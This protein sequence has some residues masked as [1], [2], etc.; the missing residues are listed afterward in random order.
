MVQMVDGYNVRKRGYQKINS[1]I[2]SI[3]G[4]FVGEKKSSD[5]L[6]EPETNIF[7]PPREAAPLDMGRD[8]FPK[9]DFDFQPSGMEAKNVPSDSQRLVD[10]AETQTTILENRQNAQVAIAGARLFAN[11]MNAQSQYATIA[12]NS[13]TN[14]FLANQSA[15]DAISRGKQQSLAAESQG[16][17]Q[18]D[19]AKLALAAQ[20]QD[21][22]GAGVGKIVAG[23]EAVGIYNGMIAEMNASREALGYEQE[24]IQYMG[25][26]EQAEIQR[27]F[28][29]LSSGL[30][31]GASTIPLG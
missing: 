18:G 13:R 8:F 30:Q 9:D 29:I 19:M 14:I 3:G 20:G 25:R 7:N 4:N 23:Q 22:Q 26:I 21:V 16:R 6:S 2:I 24:A 28:S 1:E 31:F 17:S 5:V 11:V 10:A 15:A 12:Q 27:N